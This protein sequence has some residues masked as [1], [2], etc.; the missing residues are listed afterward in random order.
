ML[1]FLKNIL[2]I[3][4]N[5]TKGWEDIAFDSRQ[6]SELCR[7]GLYPLI[8][9]TALSCAAMLYR[10]GQH[11]SFVSVIQE[12]IVTFT[13][14][15]ATLFFAQF[16]FSVTF[17]SMT[18]KKVSAKRNSTVIIYSL[19]IMAIIRIVMNLIPVDFPVLYFIAIYVGVIIYKATSFLG[20]SEDKIGNYMIMAVLSIMM[21]VF[22]L[23]FIFNTILPT[24]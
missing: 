4:I 21:P 16:M 9:I 3:L 20:V 8:G 6:P 5:P 14:Y 18:A 19:A 1:D 11:W 23:R 12:M 10:V 15:F 17:N 13:I 7:K 22:L 24:L 2:Q